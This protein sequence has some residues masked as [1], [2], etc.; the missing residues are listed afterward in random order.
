MRI[1]DPFCTA[2]RSSSLILNCF[3]EPFFRLLRLWRD[4]KARHR[5][6]KVTER[7]ASLAMRLGGRRLADYGATVSRHDFTQRQLMVLPLVHCDVGA[8]RIPAKE[9]PSTRNTAC[10]TPKSRWSASGTRLALSV[11]RQLSAELTLHSSVFSTR[12]CIRTC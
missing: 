8:G 6:R 10:T 11:F 5:V 7:V 2:C 1:F 12:A 9:M 4:G 3:A